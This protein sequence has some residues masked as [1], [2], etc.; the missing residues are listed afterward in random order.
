MGERT[1]VELY[2]HLVWGTFRR[3]P[4][5]SAELEADLFRVVITSIC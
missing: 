1:Q 2:V 5:I 3:L 4:L